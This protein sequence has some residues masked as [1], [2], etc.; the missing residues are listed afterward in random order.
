MRIKLKNASPSPLFFSL[1]SSLLLTIQECSVSSLV[2]LTTPN[3]WVNISRWSQANHEIITHRREGEGHITSCLFL[4]FLEIKNRYSYPPVSPPKSLS[5]SPFLLKRHFRYETWESSDRWGKPHDNTIYL[6]NHKKRIFLLLFT[7][8]STSVHS[9]LQDFNHH[10]H[11]DC[12]VWVTVIN[13]LFFVV[14]SSLTCDREI[15]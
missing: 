5:L 14:F 9:F 13:L 15:R 1:S 6:S 12:V 8:H 4:S 2:R 7:S 11:H 3:E 10:Y